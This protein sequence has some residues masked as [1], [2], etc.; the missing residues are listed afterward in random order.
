M[1]S[2]RGP[3]K[4]RRDSEEADGHFHLHAQ[5]GKGRPTWSKNEGVCCHLDRGVP[6]CMLQFLYTTKDRKGSH[7]Q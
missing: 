7:Q 6:A 1:N 3:D 2:M 5:L 4:I